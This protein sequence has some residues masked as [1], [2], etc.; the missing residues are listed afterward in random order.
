MTNPNFQE[1][2][3]F[4]WQVSLY[5]R[6]YP[7]RIRYIRVNDFGSDTVYYRPSAETG[8]ISITVEENAA[9]KAGYVIFGRYSQYNSE[10]HA[11]DYIDLTSVE[12]KSGSSVSATNDIT[13]QNGIGPV[14]ST[15]ATYEASNVY[16]K[17][18]LVSSNDVINAGGLY[19]QNGGNLSVQNLTLTQ[20]SSAGLYFDSNATGSIS[21]SSL[22]VSGRLYVQGGSNINIV[23]STTTLVSSSMSQVVGGSSLVV[24]GG[25][26]SVS[27]AGEEIQGFSVKQGSTLE[28]KNADVDMSGVRLQTG[29]DSSFK[30]KSAA[31]TIDNSTFKTGFIDLY[32]YTSGGAMPVINIINGSNFTG[33]FFK[34]QKEPD[35]IFDPE[36]GDYEVIY[37]TVNYYAR[38]GTI[39]VSGANTVFNVS[40]GF[41]QAENSADQVYTTVL[42][43]SDGG[44][45]NINGALDVSSVAIDNGSV[46]ADSIVVSS[47][48]NMSVTGASAVETNMLSVHEGSTVSVDETATL[49]IAKLE[50]ILSSD[51]AEGTEFN[52]NDIFGDATS[53]V[54]SAVENNVIMGDSGGNLFEAIVSE[55]GVITAGAAIPEP[56]AYAAIFGA[57]AFAFSAWR[58]RK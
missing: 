45:A 41:I 53:V 33:S 56:A 52:L 32:G 15:G 43:I 44:K 1:A 29:T 31:I 8:P 38:G 4:L 35:V 37:K 6:N 58:K 22:G 16:F 3:C 14:T 24:D 13:F 21:D 23:N 18:P 48:R 9:I 26:F 42:N 30:D 50:V 40:E 34:S 27:Q 47:G 28:F 36:T 2:P 46:S 54:L 57:L 20:S 17:S 51:I 7:L 49:D 12:F 5:S 19:Y 55:G 39:N 10:T 11:T 25:K